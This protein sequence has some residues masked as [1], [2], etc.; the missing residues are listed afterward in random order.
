MPQA[1][2]PFGKDERTVPAT[3]GHRPLSPHAL[4]SFHAP[5]II[6]DYTQKHALNF[7]GSAACEI[8]QSIKNSKQSS[9]P[10]ALVKRESSP[11]A[12]RSNGSCKP[13]PK[14]LHP[15][16]KILENA[17]SPNRVA[18]PGA[19]PPPLSLLSGNRIK[20]GRRAR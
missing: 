4:H 13:P 10:A 12:G 20:C 18:P 5:K 2:I 11:E 14:P 3:G 15:V 19:C 1:G 8:C 7:A 9:S 16:H 17:E 6:S